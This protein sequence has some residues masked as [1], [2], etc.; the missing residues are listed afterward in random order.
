[1]NRYAILVNLGEILATVSDLALDLP[2]S[3]PVE[4]IS[5]IPNGP[6]P[7]VSH[8]KSLPERFYRVGWQGVSYGFI[9]KHTRSRSTNG[10]SRTATA[11]EQDPRTWVVPHP[12]LQ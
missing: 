3:I 10:V 6:R 1:M 8:S 2:I 4:A 7:T 5:H 11:A 12:Y 9:T